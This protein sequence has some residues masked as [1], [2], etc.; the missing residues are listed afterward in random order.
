M[1]NTEGRMQQKFNSGRIFSGI[2]LI[3]VGG[4]L[5]AEKLGVIFPDWLFS[6][7][8]LL[9]ALG[10]Y[11]GGKHNFRRPGWLLLVGLGLAFLL[12]RIYPDLELSGFIFPAFLILGGI[13]MLVRPS[14]RK[15]WAD[16]NA[17]FDNA[18]CTDASETSENRL[19]V[20]AMM[21]GVKKIVLSKNFQGGEINC[22]FGGAEINLTQADIQGKVVMEVNNVF[23]GTKLF[24]PVDWEVIS[25]ATA[26][27][28]GIEDKRPVPM[29]SASASGKTLVIKGVC[30]FGGIDIRSY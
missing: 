3:L 28:G 26:I 1:E 14:R 19:E 24:V 29:V 23:G 22:I 25:E 5:F 27:L 12:A 21:G 30:V 17:S 15:R 11:T 7:P 20:I 16:A 9:I 2:I 4:A 6:W 10:F 18:A 13:F 8:M